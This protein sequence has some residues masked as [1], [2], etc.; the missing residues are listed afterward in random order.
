MCTTLEHIS[1]TVRFFSVLEAFPHPRRHMYDFVPAGA[2]VGTLDPAVGNELGAPGAWGF[3]GFSG[4]LFWCLLK[5][6]GILDAFE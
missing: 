1:I 4:Q 5:Y 6:Q 3:E 2:K